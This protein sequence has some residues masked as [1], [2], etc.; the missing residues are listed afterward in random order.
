MKS[1]VT[2]YAPHE[3]IPYFYFPT[4]SM[5]SVVS[6]LSDGSMV[7]A[8]VIGREGVAGI[9]ALL[10]VESTPH[11]NVVQLPG[12][13]LRIKTKTLL[14]EFKRAVM[15]HDS[16]LRYVYTLLTQLDKRRRA[17]GYTRLKKDW[18]AGC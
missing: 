8:G 15:L 17:T 13:A 14:E 2:L 12:S 16:I 11:E 3:A 4:D 6:V 10:G 1:G 7:E 5:V 9:P 18:R